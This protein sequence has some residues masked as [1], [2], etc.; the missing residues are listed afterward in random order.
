[1]H[2][3]FSTARGAS[4]PAMVWRAFERLP[5]S[6]DVAES[7]DV[8]Q[9]SQV[10]LTFLARREQMVDVG[11]D[12]EY[13]GLLQLIAAPIHC[14]HQWRTTLLEMLDL[15]ARCSD[16]ARSLAERMVVAVFKQRERLF[17]RIASAEILPHVVVNRRKLRVVKEVRNPFHVA[18][19]QRH[20]AHAAGIEGIVQRAPSVAE[21][22]GG[23]AGSHE[24]T[25]LV[26]LF[27][28][29]AD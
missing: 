24:Q 10:P 22:L 27:D 20:R 26:V 23:S 12:K 15:R 4:V 28:G 2:T 13:C 1:M 5:R 9:R 29:H 11:L 3:A 7:F 17:N 19:E 16:Q 25:V 18:D 6:M 8:M 14:C 21:V